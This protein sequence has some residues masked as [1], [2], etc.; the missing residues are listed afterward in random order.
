MSRPASLV[1]SI[2]LIV[3]AALQL[4]RFLFGISVIIGGVEIPRWPSA[5][6]AIVPASIALW[7]LKERNGRAG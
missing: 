4:C 6:A 7:L 5:I 1:A 2:L 3:V